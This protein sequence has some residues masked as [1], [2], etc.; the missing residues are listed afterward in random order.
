MGSYPLRSIQSTKN[1]DKICDLL[2][3]FPSPRFDTCYIFKQF[4][5][6]LKK[7]NCHSVLPYPANNHKPPLSS[8]KRHL[9]GCHNPLCGLHL[10]L[11]SLDWK[12]R[13]YL[14]LMMMIQWQEVCRCTP[15]QAEWHLFLITALILFQYQQLA[16]EK[17]TLELQ[18]SSVCMACPMGHLL[19]VVM[20]TSTGEGDLAKSI[21]KES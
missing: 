4:I 13:L 7:H 12:M 3:R 16:K 21:C 19:V 18:S 8:K 10:P 11:G 5:A 6:L 17:L 20:V 1:C 14:R 9:L 15:E 2:K